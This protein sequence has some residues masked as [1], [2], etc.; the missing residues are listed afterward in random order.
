M[1]TR[2]NIVIENGSSRIYIYRHWDGYLAEAGA[3]ILAKLK[4]SSSPSRFLE[5]LLAERYEKQSYE[6]EAKRVYE[7]TTEVHGD[8]EYLYVIKFRDVREDLRIGYAHRKVYSDGAL[9]ERDV[10]LGGVESF[11][12]AVNAEIR[13]TNRRLAKLRA[14]QPKAY[15]EVADYS[16][17]SA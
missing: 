3:D 12:Q 8:I 2:S 1:S 11:V 10:V 16:E 17:V 5:L 9:E 4:A 7:L 15:G 13:E 6:T 14:E